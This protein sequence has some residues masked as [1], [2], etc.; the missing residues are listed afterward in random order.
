MVFKRENSRIMFKCPSCERTKERLKPNYQESEIWYNVKFLSTESD[1][2]FDAPG[3]LPE[4][5]NLD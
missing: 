4:S 5:Y 3:I 1:G 2:R